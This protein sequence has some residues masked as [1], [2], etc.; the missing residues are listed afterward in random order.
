MAGLNR[1]VTVPRSLN[2]I[3]I[4]GG[5][6]TGKSTLACRLGAHLD[7]PVYQ[8]DTVAYEGPEFVERSLEYRTA[9][10]GEIAAQ[11]RWVAEGIFIGWTDPLLQRADVIVWLDYVSWRSA[12]GRLVVRFVRDAV[13]EARVRRGV[14]RFLRISDY[15]RNLRQLIS[16]LVASRE[17]WY[18]QQTRRYPVTRER[19]VQA[20][21]PHTEKVV[22]VRRQSDAKALG[23]FA[24]RAL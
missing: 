2:R 13:T 21:S 1:R 3:Y 24:E 8:L 10:A 17:Y 23:V 14:E 7:M 9:R 5:P 6:A 19:M 22:H 12:A 15:R 20:L 16:V 11:P 18:G 4:V